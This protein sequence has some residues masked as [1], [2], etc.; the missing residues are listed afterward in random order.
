MKTNVK[1]NRRMSIL[2]LSLCVSCGINAQTSYC[3]PS[4]G[5]TTIGIT[6][7]QYLSVDNYTGYTTAYS[8]YSNLSGS[9]PLGPQGPA[10]SQASFSPFWVVVGVSTTA[11]IQHRIWIDWNEDGDF[12]DANETITTSMLS[13]GLFG[14]QITVPKIYYPGGWYYKY[15][16]KRM[17]VRM[18]DGPVT[19]SACGSVTNG[20]AED[21]SIIVARPP[22]G[23]GAPKMLDLTTG[24]M[25]NTV[26][27]IQSKENKT[28]QVTFPRATGNGQV[29]VINV[30]GQI[31]AEQTVNLSENN[32]CLV[33]LSKLESGMYIVKA[34]NGS[35]VSGK[36]IM[37]Q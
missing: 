9:V 18:C 14:A 21:Y 7:V 13:G 19:L 34:V 32:V 30:M 26:I 27:D 10:G 17:R 3:I 4:A 16:R 22:S 1:L 6:E 33:D 2:L 24:E 31:V 8:D 20:E 29:V 25:E 15:G 37:I 11:T 5:A 35:T 23:P 28:Y 12:S 36:K